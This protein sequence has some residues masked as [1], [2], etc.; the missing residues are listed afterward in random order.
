MEPWPPS[1]VAIGSTAVDTQ[2]GRLLLSLRAVFC[3]PRHQSHSHTGF[4]PHR[5][6]SESK[7]KSGWVSFLVIPS[8]VCA[9]AALDLPDLLNQILHF[10]KIPGRVECSAKA[11][12]LCST[13]PPWREVTQW[14]RPSP[15]T[16]VMAPETQHAKQSTQVLTRRRKQEQRKVKGTQFCD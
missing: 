9:S 10:D 6:A 8:M 3:S 5:T 7:S 16:R 13:P 12:K 2:L 14:C 4:A 11:E 15:L 1:L